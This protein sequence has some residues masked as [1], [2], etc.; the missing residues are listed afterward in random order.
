[1]QEICKSGS[2][3]GLGQRI[4]GR[5]IVAPPGNQAVKGENKDMFFNIPFYLLFMFFFSGMGS[6]VLEILWQRKLILV[7]GASAPATTAIFAA[8][9]LGMAGGS[10]IAPRMFRFF[11]NSLRYY[12]FIE[13]WIVVSALIFPLLL[14]L[15]DVI[16]HWVVSNTGQIF[17]LRFI[18]VVASILPATLGMGATIPVMNR[19]LCEYVGNVGKGVAIAYGLNTIGAVSGCLLAGFVLLPE[20]GLE[21]T[22][23][24]AISIDAIIA[25]IA[26]VLSGK[27]IIETDPGPSYNFSRSEW[28]TVLLYVFASFISMSYE[29]L[30]FR[31]LA[32]LNTNSIYTFTLALSVYLLG[33]GL[34]SI[35]LF[36]IL[37]K[38]FSPSWCFFISMFGIAISALFTFI[39][40]YRAYKVTKY[41]MLKGGD[42]VIPELII[43]L[44]LILLPTLFMGMAFP[45]ICGILAEKKSIGRVSGITYS[46]GNLGA[47]LGII[48]SGLWLIPLLGI[49]GMYTFLS[50][51]LFVI[52]TV[53]WIKRIKNGRRLAF[54]STSMILTGTALYF[55]LYGAPFAKL[56]AWEKEGDS[57]VVK[58]PRS[59]IKVLRYESGQS[60]TIAV[61]DFYTRS[62]PVVNRAIAV[63]DQIVASTHADMLV[64]SKMLAHLPLMLHSRPKKALTVGFGSGG[65]SWSM[66]LHGI[67]VRAVEIEK[68]VINSA[69][70]FEDCNHGVLN[71]QNFNLVLDDARHFLKNTNFEFDVISTDCTNVKYKQNSSLYTK[72]YFELM[73]RRLSAD[74]V[75]CAWIPNI[76]ISEND[77]KILLRT[78]KAVFPHASYWVFDHVMP[79]FGILIGTPKKMEIDMNGLKS[80]FS[81]DKV[82]SDMAQIGI[83]HPYQMLNYLYLD[84][85]GFDNYTGKG[86]IHTDDLPILEFSRI[87]TVSSPKF[88]ETHMKDMIQFKPNDVDKHVI[89]LGE[90]ERKKLRSFKDFSSYVSPFTRSLYRDDPLSK[91]ALKDDID[92]LKKALEVFPDYQ[93]GKLLLERLEQQKR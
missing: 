75:A 77:F 24:T 59:M 64:D 47:M 1:M 52:V 32:I 65:T 15:N 13:A 12:A 22:L 86:P 30:W 93:W 69:Y 7:F 31:H 3:R 16:Y 2:V 45:S 20:I 51:N 44:L 11:K 88:L 85:E 72:E 18:F 90:E 25:A 50:S 56:Y 49:V 80:V 79:S 46:L 6:L 81:N 8:F 92:N 76:G 58:S 70:L 39:L 43:S 5:N 35:V 23:L 71:A 91:A 78:F 83:E 21:K 63:D 38:R 41:F 42:I 67:D 29:V 89:G 37:I 4:H 68:E 53:V 82:F 28:G 84:R 62:S 14:S 54:I 27:K 9:F 26:F 36:Q 55:G 10:F 73:K 40:S 61:E 19:I 60:A 34:G 48:V 33:F 74:G 17:F 66:S 87:A 57:F